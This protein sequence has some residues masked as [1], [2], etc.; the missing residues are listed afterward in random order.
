M[1]L[2]IG[3][4]GGLYYLIGFPEA[5][6]RVLPPTLQPKFAVLPFESFGG[7]EGVSDFTDGIHDELIRDLGQIHSMRVISRQ[8]VMQYRDSEKTLLQ[9]AEELGVDA[10]LTG[11]VQRAGDWVRIGISLREG[12]HETQLWE[13][14]FEFTFTPGN[15][16]DVQAEAD[17]EIYALKG[18][19]DMI[20][21]REAIHAA[22][23]QSDIL[24]P[25]EP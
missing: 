5:P 18:E 21:Q 3:G 2:M 19:A 24:H 15:F 12:R 23:G 1:L 20:E 6:K 16:F 10:V 9:I 13:D 8:S 4:T 17:V 11:V 22:F 7:A 25:S 14:D